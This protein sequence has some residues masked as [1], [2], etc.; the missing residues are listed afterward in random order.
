MSIQDEQELDLQLGEARMKIDEL[1]KKLYEVKAENAKLKM[2]MIKI[3]SIT[4]EFNI[5]NFSIEGKDESER[6][7]L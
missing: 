6:G 2:A 7:S 1:L 4:E 5:H 3:Q